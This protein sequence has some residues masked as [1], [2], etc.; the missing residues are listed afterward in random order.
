MAEDFY[1]YYFK[2]T[3]MVKNKVKPS[4]KIYCKMNS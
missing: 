3:N 1:K 2:Y 4:F